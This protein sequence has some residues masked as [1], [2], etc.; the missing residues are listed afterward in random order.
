[1]QGCFIYRRYARLLLQGSNQVLL[2]K[3][4]TTQDDP[5]S[6]MMYSTVRFKIYICTHA[7]SYCTQHSWQCSRVACLCSRVAHLCSRVFSSARITIVHELLFNEQLARELH[8]LRE[9]C[10][11]ENFVKSK[12]L[13]SYQ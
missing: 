10:L 4:G 12:F 9:K 7:K 13:A 5:L 11:R 6:I 2:S 3:E 1:M 8:T